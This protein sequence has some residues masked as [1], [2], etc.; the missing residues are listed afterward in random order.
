MIHDR[1][2]LVKIVEELTMFFF[3]IGGNDIT[4]RIQEVDHTA[5]ITFTSNYN[6]KCAH[7]L[8]SLKYFLNSEKDDSIEDV[9]W[10]LAGVCECSDTSQLLLLGMMVD[11]A[12]VD[13][14]D[15]TVTVRLEKYI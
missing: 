14:T 8:K 6:L 7:K 2:K 12:S 10:E 15:D 5:I 4:S 13:I 9:Y 11:S 3:G 1:K